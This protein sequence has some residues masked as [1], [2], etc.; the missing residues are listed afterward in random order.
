MTFSSKTHFIGLH[1][2]DDLI[3]MGFNVSD[4][5]EEV[6]QDI[7][8]IDFFGTK[9]LSLEEEDYLEPINEEDE[10]LA[11]KKL[12]LSISFLKGDLEEINT[13]LGLDTM[14]D[15]GN[16]VLPS[17]ISIIDN[18]NDSFLVFGKITKSYFFINRLFLCGQIEDS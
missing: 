18:I 4:G 6:Y 9:Y 12:L 14:F 13:L 17:S 2:P 11:E 3:L 5:K 15:M 10:Y 7:P 16:V 1:K 8:L